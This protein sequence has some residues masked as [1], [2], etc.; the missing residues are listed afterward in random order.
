MTYNI[1][2]DRVE[3]QKFIDITPRFF[4]IPLQIEEE[5]CRQVNKGII[6]NVG[7]VKIIQDFIE[8]SKIR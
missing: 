3:K 4:D 6:I 1:A 5:L 7:E 8:R 2:G